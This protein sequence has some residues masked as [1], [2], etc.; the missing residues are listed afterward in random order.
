MKI[1]QISIQGCNEWNEDASVVN[2]KY[3]IY[4][5]MDG[6][7]SEASRPGVETGGYLASHSVQQY[8]ES[9][10]DETAGLSLRKH[11]VRANERI[12]A[13]MREQGVDVE[14]KRILWATGLAVV[15]IGEYQIEYAQ[16]GDCMI[17][18]VYNDGTVRTVTHDQVDHFD[19]KTR[20]LWEQCLAEGLTPKQT[21]ERAFQA[22]SQNRLLT[23]TTGG[24][25]I[26]NGDPMLANYVE[27]GMLNRIQLRTLYL[28]TDGLFLPR[29]AGHP[30]PPMADMVA[31]IEQKGLQGYAEWLVANELDESRQALYT[32]LKISDDKTAIRID[33]D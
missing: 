6:A 21:R 8:F 22:I 25:G 33:L 31:L 29:K 26:L 1:E 5:V 15:R 17:V 12:R 28:I 27:H 18:A 11:A 13:M 16:T 14:D 7:T 4:G 23:N 9:L 10:D 24:Y 32:R 20:L 30:S 3:R 2:D 19:E